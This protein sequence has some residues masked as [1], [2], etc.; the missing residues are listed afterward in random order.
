MGLR[1]EEFPKFG[2]EPYS[3]YS[4]EVPFQC[5]LVFRAENFPTLR[6]EL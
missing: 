6:S 3:V 2:R 5:E 1:N 4:Q